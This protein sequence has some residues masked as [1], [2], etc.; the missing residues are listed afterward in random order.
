MVFAALVLRPRLNR[1]ANIALSAI[2]ALTIIVGAIGEWA[3][4]ILG[5]A[6]EVGLL[7]AI[8]Y[9]ALT[10]PKE[11]APPTSAGEREATPHHI[12]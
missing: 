1:L 2:Y 6:V 8:V 12:H 5:S 9:Y 11:L 7:A 4:Y 10:W 3:Y